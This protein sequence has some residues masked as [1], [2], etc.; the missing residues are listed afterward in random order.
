M[1]II[2]KE[3]STRIKNELLFLIPA[4]Q[5][6]YV[7]NRFINENRRVIS[8]ILEISNILAIEG[9]LVTVVIKEA[10]DSVSYCKFL[11]TTYANDT[12]FFL[13]DRKSIIELMNELNTFSNFSWLKPN[14]TK[15]KIAG[16]GVLN[17]VQVALWCMKCINLNSETVKMIDVRFSYN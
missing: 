16:I 8:A 12:N 3:L 11:C 1:K 10:F 6:A 4:N 9:F 17:G 14:K 13:K 2:S 7:K 5:T 15:C